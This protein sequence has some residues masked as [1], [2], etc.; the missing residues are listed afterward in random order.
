MNEA[1]DHPNWPGLVGRHRAETKPARR[2][3]S[4]EACQR[5]RGQRGNLAWQGL[6]LHQRDRKNGV[7]AESPEQNAL[8][9]CRCECVSH[10]ST[11]KERAL[12][13]DGPGGEMEPEAMAGREMETHPPL[14]ALL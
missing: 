12:G 11:A 7:R 9:G 5:P 10:R 4:R 13:Q 6:L 8:N 2:C 1:N 14:G 3:S